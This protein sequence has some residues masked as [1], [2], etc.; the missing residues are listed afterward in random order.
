MVTKC[1]K[2]SNYL[3]KVF[4]L[5]NIILSILCAFVLVAIILFS[6]MPIISPS[7][8]ENGIGQ[9]KTLTPDISYP[10]FIFS[11]I[12]CLIKLLFILLFSRNA[13]KLFK[14]II[15]ADTPFSFQNQKALKVCSISFFLYYILPVYPYENLQLYQIITGF[16]VSSLIYIFSLVIE[17]GQKKN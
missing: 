4:Y 17:E 2:Y 14:N 10:L 5:T 8:F 3:Y 1:Q 13:K 12:L 9:L 16:F 11:L 15:D 6:L 7:Q